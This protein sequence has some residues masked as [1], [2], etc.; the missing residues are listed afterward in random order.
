[1]ERSD[2]TRPREIAASGESLAILAAAIACLPEIQRSV[3]IHRE[4]QE[5]SYEEAAATLKVPLHQMKVYL[6][7][8]RM[9][10]REILRERMNHG[11]I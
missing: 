4:L 10:L 3:V 8:A 6:H 9:R 5:L 1:M 2:G 7:R 11:E